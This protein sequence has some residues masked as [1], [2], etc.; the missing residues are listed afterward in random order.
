MENGLLL[1]QIQSVWLNLSGLKIFTVKVSFNCFS[2]ITLTSFTSS[3]LRFNETDHLASADAK[4]EL[5]SEPERL[6]MRSAL[7]TRAVTARGF[8]CAHSFTWQ[9]H[10]GEAACVRHTAPAFIVSVEVGP[11]LWATALWASQVMWLYSFPGAR[12]TPGGS[13]FWMVTSHS[14]AFKMWTIKQLR[15]CQA[16]KHSHFLCPA[17]NTAG[18]AKTCN[19][20]CL[21]LYFLFSWDFILE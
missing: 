16:L 18:R 11:R 14:S 10:G 7:E 13:L 15:Q 12:G 20:C 5:A 1:N 2:W 4:P 6:S 19:I 21:M 3:L 8:F 9:L 17:D